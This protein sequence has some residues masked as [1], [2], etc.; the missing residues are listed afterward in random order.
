MASPDIGSIKCPICEHPTAVVR[1]QKT[2]RALIT[3]PECS[4]QL[5]SRGEKSD[6]CIREKMKRIHVEID[7]PGDAVHPVKKGF[8]DEFFQ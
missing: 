3:C 2:G 1:Q 7:Q 8:L 6:K 5:F 4:Y